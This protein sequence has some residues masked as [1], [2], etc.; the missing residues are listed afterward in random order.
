MF[1]SKSNAMQQ[2]KY[3]CIST[4][5]FH[6]LKEFESMLTKFSNFNKIK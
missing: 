6:K 4:K 5:T 1:P 2:K 3:I